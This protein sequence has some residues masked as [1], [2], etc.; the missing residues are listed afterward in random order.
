MAPKTRLK[1]AAAPINVPQTR[2]SVAACIGEIGALSRNLQRIEHDMNDAL[3][4]LKAGFEEQAAPLRARITALTG[5]VQIYGEA[6]RD[7]LTQ[8][9]K[10]KTV[11]FPTGE[12]LWRLNPPSVRLTDSEANIIEALEAMG[13]QAFVRYTPTLNKDAIK[14]DPDAARNVPGLK[15]AQSEA[16]V[17]VPFEIALAETA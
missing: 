4:G 10:V 3:T 6:N 7:L 2:E 13:L 16:F 17:V 1:T 12:I 5:G 8:N 9:G 15:I 11:A 14:A